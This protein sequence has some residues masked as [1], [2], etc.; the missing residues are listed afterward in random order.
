MK[1]KILVSACLLGTPCR[2]DGST[3]GI[4]AV[5]QLKE[6]YEVVAFCPEVLGG[7]KIPRAACECKNGRVVNKL[8]LDVTAEF[9]LGAEKAAE[10]ALRFGCQQA[11][12]KANSPSCGCGIIYDGSFQGVKI[13][14]NGVTA[15]KL[16]ELGLNIV[17]ENT[18]AQLK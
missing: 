17:N 13:S 18:L 5:K 7:L 10:L 15:K 2:Y 1:E 14:G 6:K 9:T 11:V 3:K 8:G 4:E 12:L 16:L